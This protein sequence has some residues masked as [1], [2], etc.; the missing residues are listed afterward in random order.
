MLLPD[1]VRTVSF[2]EFVQDSELRLRQALSAL[3]GPDAGRDAAA[4]AFVYAWEHWDR[5]RV[6]ENPVGYLYRVG[7][8]SG[9]RSVKRRSV[10]LP[11]VPEAVLPWVEP[12]LPM[13]MQRLPD[14]QRQVVFLLHAH[15]WSMAEVAELLGVSKST[16]QSYADR[17]MQ[18]LRRS[19]KVE[20]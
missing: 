6:M 2:V 5:V 9:R 11:A 13:A 20:S 4:D 12:G 1:E 15:D 17:A 19:L 10:E 18:R 14:R 16:V 7:Q 3:F 8:T